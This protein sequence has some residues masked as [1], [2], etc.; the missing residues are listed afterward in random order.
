MNDN[1]H[2]LREAQ[3]D[4]L[5]RLLF[6]RVPG[7]CGSAGYI[8]QAVEAPT[9]NAPVPTDPPGQADESRDSGSSENGGVKP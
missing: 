4:S 7:V 9:G 6:Q 5:V 1:L 2:P 8:G 3:D